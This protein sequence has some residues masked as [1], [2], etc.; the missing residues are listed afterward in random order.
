MGTAVEMDTLVLH[1]KRLPR[2]FEGMPAML[3]KVTTL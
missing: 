1:K 2:R 3:L